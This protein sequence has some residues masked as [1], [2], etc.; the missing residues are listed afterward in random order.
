MGGPELSPADEIQA[1]LIKFDAALQKEDVDQV[2][3]LFAEPESFWRDLLAFTWTI[4]TFETRE[5]IASML[6]ETLTRVKPTGWKIHGPA[7]VKPMMIGAGIKFETSVAWGRGF[8]YL[9]GGK[10][11]TMMTTMWELKGHEEK[12]A[13][14]RPLGPQLGSV[15]GRK[16]WIEE[17]QEE[18]ADLGHAKQP[19]CLIVGGGQAGLMLGAYLRVLGV[20]TIIVEKN[21]RIGDTWRN[22]YRTL[23]LHTPFFVDQFPY[24]PYPSNWPV[25]P[26][27]DK[28]ADWFECYATLMEL[29]CWCSTECKAASFD[30]KEGHWEVVLEKKNPEDGSL[31]TVVVKPSHLVLS[32]GLTGFPEIPAFKGADTFEGTQF[33]SSEYQTGEQWKGKKAIV[34]GACT[35]AH[36]I[37]LDLWEQGASEVTMAQRSESIVIKIQT[38]LDSRLDPDFKATEYEHGFDMDSFDIKSAALPFKVLPRVLVPLY[39]RIA[40][41]ESEFHESLRK[42]G[43]KLHM[44]EDGTGAPAGILRRIGGYYIDVGASELIVNGTVKVK[45][46]VEEIK[47]K[48]VVFTD[49]SEVSAD[50][51]IYA[52][53]YGNI[54]DYIEKLIPKEAAEKVGL[55]WGLGSNTRKDPGPWQRELRNM[56]KPIAVPNLWI[57]AGA[58]SHCRFYGRHVALQLKARFEGIPTPVYTLPK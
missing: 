46:G 43:F 21:T 41:K 6:K 36:D 10:C 38:F 27:K 19:Y 53:G 9:K 13:R 18:R 34:V 28:L 14:S 30:E 15:T 4:Q 3:E 1:W 58:Y 5:E 26:T 50:L 22:R 57:V 52:T 35:S 17:L 40:E 31:Q 32:C 12:I 25:L 37:C 54:H 8:L 11:W 56:W 42:V 20:P 55:C 29:D 49:G 44:G 16:T 45:G 39:N 33:H 24:L 2:M 48:S 47:P 7:F 51:I 23:A